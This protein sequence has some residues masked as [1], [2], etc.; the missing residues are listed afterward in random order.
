MNDF[1]R[2]QPNNNSRM[3]K[4][5]STPGGQQPPPYA[6]LGASPPHNGGG[7]G[8]ENK[9]KGLVVRKISK[10]SPSQDSLLHNDSIA[11]ASRED[12]SRKSSLEGGGGKLSN[13]AAEDI[14]KDGE[15]II[16]ADKYI[17]QRQIGKGSFGEVYRGYNKDTK[18]LVAI[19]IVSHS[20][21]S[22]CL[23]RCFITL[24]ITFTDYE[25]A[26]ISIN[27]YRKSPNL[28]KQELKQKLKFFQNFKVMVSAILN[29]S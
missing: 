5:N 6:V 15:F 20:L 26:N 3:L 18:E 25:S 29:F 22:I 17:I 9:T 24:D 1:S 10:A 27:Y 21:L 12:I 2:H 13:N 28:C 4:M 16:V 19:K 11:P 8:P 7:G 23:L 14:D